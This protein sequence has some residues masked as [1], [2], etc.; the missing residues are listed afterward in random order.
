M[1]PVRMPSMVI[2]G[3]VSCAL[4]VHAQS[5]YVGATNSNPLASA[6]GTQAADA[7]SYAMQARALFDR[8]F[9]IATNAV[10][11][12]C[13]VQEDMERPHTIFPALNAYDIMNPADGFPNWVD[14]RTPFPD[15]LRVLTSEQRDWLKKNYMV[16]IDLT[17]YWDADKGKYRSERILIGTWIRAEIIPA[18]S[19]EA[20]IQITDAV[21]DGKAHSINLSTVAA[22][23][24][25]STVS[26]A[27]VGQY[28]TESGRAVGS[29]RSTVRTCSV[30]S[31]PDFRVVR[32]KTFYFS[33]AGEARVVGTHVMTYDDN[34]ADTPSKWIQ[35]LRS[36]TK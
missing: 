17:S 9:E 34:L 4:S 11:A 35:R 16:W 12:S 8:V 23:I 18:Y 27:I 1:H 7:L 31:C 2:I 33:P 15:A 10:A 29:A 20:P 30:V 32:R 24:V 3:C 6:V 28:V 36:G 21:R 13:S 25:D 22:V 26:S 5:I 14:L 19:A